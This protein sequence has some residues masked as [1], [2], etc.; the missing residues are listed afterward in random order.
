MVFKTKNVTMKVNA[1]FFDKTF[2]PARKR[3]EK[4]IG[5]RV[6]QAAFTEMLHKSKI[7]LELKF[8][9]LPRKNARKNNKK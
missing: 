5:V 7:K 6:S 8:N 1:D 2:E 3:V 9:P 4:Q